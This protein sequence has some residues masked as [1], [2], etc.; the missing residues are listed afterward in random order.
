MTRPTILASWRA[1]T[2]CPPNASASSSS[3]QSSIAATRFSGTEKVWEAVSTSIPRM[4]SSL[5]G[6]ST[7]LPR[8]SWRPSR[9]N[10]LSSCGAQSSAAVRSLNANQRSSR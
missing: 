3:A 6:S 10:R 5:V 4:R 8:L 9:L 2:C 1:R 7:D